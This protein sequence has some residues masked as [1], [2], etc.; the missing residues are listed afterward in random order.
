MT[1]FKKWITAVIDDD[2]DYNDVCELFQSINNQTSNTRFEYEQKGN[3]ISIKAKWVD[4]PL[5][6]V[7]EK[8]TNYLLDYLRENYMEGMDVESYWSYKYNLEKE[9]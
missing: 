1:D 8:Q 9:D 5:I 2:D 7:T 4:D 6:L 3:I